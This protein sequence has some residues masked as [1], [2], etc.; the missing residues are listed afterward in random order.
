MP[1]LRIT[2]AV[3]LFNKAA[4]IGAALDSVL[5]QSV[6]DFDIVV[7]DDGS[8]DEGP[9]IVRRLVDPRITLHR[10]ANG[11]VS[12][13]RNVAL[14]LARGE[15][16]AFL[17]ADDLWRPR[18][19]E[20]LLALQER[21]P[22][23]ALYGNA[24][25]AVENSGVKIVDKAVH[26]QRLDDYFARWVKGPEPFYTSSSMAHRSTA[27][28]IGGFPEGFSRGEDLT[29]FVRMALAG[30][31]AVSDYVGCLYLRRAGGLTS[32]PLLEDDICTTTILRLLAEPSR[33]SA[34][35]RASLLE[36]VNKIAVA[37]ALDCVKAGYT[38]EALRFLEASAGTRAQRRRW[39]QARLLASCPEPVRA[40]AFSMRDLGR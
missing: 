10:Q 9:D 11:G 14:K 32:T 21:W 23:A 4:H 28:D 29:F 16:V 6:S 36:F 1:D 17:D 26:Y 12:A 30:A 18:H 19:L 25:V 31:V 20:H 2:V 37:N 5:R 22:D 15:F 35:T 7:V 38:A 24:F 33:I 39:W 3:S 27:L 13:A 8:T 40:L 34:A